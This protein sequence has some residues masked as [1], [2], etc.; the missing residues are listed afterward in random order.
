MEQIPLQEVQG[1][2]LHSY[3]MDA[4]RVFV[5]RV[6]RA[7]QARLLLLDFPI[8]N[9]VIWDKKPDFCLNIAITYDGPQA[10]GLDQR[11]RKL[12]RWTGRP[13]RSR[14]GLTLCPK[15][16]YSR[17]AEPTAAGTLDWCDE[18]AFFP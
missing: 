4:L 15:R 18:R 14:A 11:A 8:T 13:R 6:E 9:A 1:L 7:A 5:S 17:S 2:I 16:R 12:E 3:G 10:L